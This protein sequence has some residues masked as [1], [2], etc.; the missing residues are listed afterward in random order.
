[1]N[2]QNMTS[3]RGN[4][5]PNQFIITT[6][7]GDYFQSYKTMIAFRPYA[8]YKGVGAFR[9]EAYNP[10]QLDRDAWNYSKTTSKYRNMFLGDT[11]ADVKRKLGVFSPLVIPG[12]EE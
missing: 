7:D 12:I 8:S 11:S 2:M 4:T 1:M 10:I 5:V 3:S 6:P 9:Y